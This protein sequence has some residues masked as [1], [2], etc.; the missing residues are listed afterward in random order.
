MKVGWKQSVWWWVTQFNA[1]IEP[2][3]RLFGVNPWYRDEIHGI[4][5]PSESVNFS[6]VD[7]ENHHRFGFLSV[8][9][10]SLGASTQSKLL[11]QNDQEVTL[12]GSQTTLQRYPWKPHFNKFH[13][14]Y[15]YL[16]PLTYLFM[17]V[18]AGVL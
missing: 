18:S 17:L 11:L 9:N 14:K 10:I 7:S 1:T 6:V 15:L 5:N 13:M 16:L 3:E 4:A 8:D 2:V 12:S